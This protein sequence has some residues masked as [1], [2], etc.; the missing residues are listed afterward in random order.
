MNYKEECL[1]A[2]DASSSVIGMSIFNLKSKEL[3]KID[4]LI[5]DKSTSLIERCLAYEK[6]L[7]K[8]RLEYNITE[9]AIEQSFSGFFGGGSSA[10]TIET[11][12]CVNFGYRLLTH[13]LG[14]KVNT[15]TVSDSRKN[16]FPN[17]K[18]RTLAKLKG[19][20]EKEYCFNLAIDKYGDLVKPYLS[21]KMI[22]KGKRKGVEVYNDWCFDCID[23][24][25][26]GTGYLNSL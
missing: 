5:H 7:I 26:V 11:L 19:V 21:T 14:I 18:I 22:S 13:K 6:L 20:K 10:A 4:Y 3:I 24:F 16:T 8:L 1:L 12:T 2:L 17:I 23:A 9:I 25:I 15:I